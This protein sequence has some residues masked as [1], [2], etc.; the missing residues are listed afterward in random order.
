MTIKET[1]Q[2]AAA[3]WETFHNPLLSTLC[4]RPH[5]LQPG[6]DSVSI[7]TDHYTATINR[8]GAITYTTSNG[9]SP[10]DISNNELINHAFH[11]IPEADAEGFIHGTFTKAISTDSL[12]LHGHIHSVLFRKYKHIDNQDFNPDA[13]SLYKQIVT[14]HN[15]ATIILDSSQIASVNHFLGEDIL[16]AGD[17]VILK[18]P[19]AVPFKETGY[20]HCISIQ[21]N[22]DTEYLCNE[23]DRIIMIN[24]I[25]SVPYTTVLDRVSKKEMDTLVFALFGKNQQWFCGDY[26]WEGFALGA[27]LGIL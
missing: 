5:T 23:N 12:S 6:T 27:K 9:S 7:V 2:F 13:E 15:H 3:L 18:S 16:L 26:E 1:I 22:D 25:W 21:Q 10:F 8:N 24:R 4:N 17:H 11:H 20:A 14:D 19:Q